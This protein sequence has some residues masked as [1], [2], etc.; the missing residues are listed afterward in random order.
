M[1]TYRS[2]SACALFSKWVRSMS[3]TAQWMVFVQLIPKD[4]RFHSSTS[5]YHP[6]DVDRRMGKDKAMMA[7]KRVRPKCQR[8][9]NKITGDD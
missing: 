3:V 9:G 6:S 2:I 4:L 1:G 5:N 7:V 8:S